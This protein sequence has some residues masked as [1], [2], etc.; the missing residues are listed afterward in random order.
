MKK[1]LFV[2]IATILLATGCQKTEI[3]NRT[4][5]AMTFS[6]EMGKLTKAADS[7][8]MANLQAY[9]FK[10]WAYRNFTDEYFSC[11]AEGHGQCKGLNHIYDGMDAINVTYSNSKWGTEKDYYWP[12]TDKQLKFYAVSSAADFELTATNVVI[13]QDGT[14]TGTITVK[15]F[16]VT[17]NADNDLMIADPIT[18]AQLDP[19]NGNA[20]KPQFRHTLSKVQFNFRTESE[21]LEEHPVYIQSITTSALKFKGTIT[22]PM[23]ANAT[24]GPWTLTEDT[25]AFTDNNTTAITLPTTGGDTPV[26]ITVDGEGDVKDRTGLTL[27]TSFQTLDTW[28]LLPQDL[29]NATFT[30]TYII[31]NRQFTRTLSLATTG[32]TSWNTNQFIKYN[33]VVAPN[34]VTF[35]PSVEDWVETNVSVN[36][37]GS[38][39]VTPTTYDVTATE[40]G[41][42]VK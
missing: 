7:E 3:F 28:L 14:A 23:A 20:V 16:Q 38:T 11:N 4:G 41:Q 21:T 34:L 1:I 6:S 40:G 22:Y 30:I 10:V 42:T 9:G 19:T 15:D 35:E 32:L 36:D 12:G 33:V 26:E 5:D 13:A 31:K 25:K 29:S 8:G 18:Q 27:T 17:N 24:T 39:V 37:N 2:A